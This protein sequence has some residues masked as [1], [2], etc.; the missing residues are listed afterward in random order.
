[1]PA[2]YVPP[3]SPYVARARA[4]ARANA[5][6]ADPTT[7]ILI[8][9]ADWLKMAALEQVRD[10]F[11]QGQSGVILIGMPGLEKRLARYPQ[12]Y[13]RLLELNELT[14]ITPAVVA[15]AR[16]SLVLGAA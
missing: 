11:D 3:P 14:T 4:Y 15:A 10:I 6:L 16:E 8:D 7:L 2:V 12:L 13:S 5:Q 9:E 1:L